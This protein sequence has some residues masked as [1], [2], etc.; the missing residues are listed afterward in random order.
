[1]PE[2]INF[3]NLAG[4]SD[5][6]L[7][8]ESSETDRLVDSAVANFQKKDYQGL[9]EDLLKLGQ[10]L[11]VELETKYDEVL[12]LSQQAADFIFGQDKVNLKKDYIEKKVI[13]PDKEQEKSAKKEG[14]SLGVIFPGQI[15]R[16]EFLTAFKTKYA[17]EFSSEGLWQAD[18]AKQDLNQTSAVKAP[19]RPNKSYLLMTSPQ[20]EVDQAELASMATTMNK[21]PEQA[22]AILT[23]KQQESPELNLQ[24][25]TLPEYLFLDT[26]HYLKT[27]KHLDENHWSYLLGER[28]PGTLRALGANWFADRRRVGVD[29]V[30]V[31]GGGL[32]SR[33]AA[34]PSASAVST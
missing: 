29:S 9:D 11:G 23:K 13:L 20:G 3:N 7:E 32:G 34:V 31:A 6:S 24:G 19:N 33:F 22:E 8:Q 25:L 15:P 12:K 2:Q 28:V 1:M 27:Q 10:E 18:Q 30:S 17:Q 26:C 4:G 5:D 16:D 14:L 21:T